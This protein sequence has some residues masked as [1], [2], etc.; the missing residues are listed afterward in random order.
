MARTSGFGFFPNQFC[1][2]GLQE[3]QVVLD[4]VPDNSVIHCVAPMDKPVSQANDLPQLWNTIL[5]FRVKVDCA[6]EGFPND[7]EPALD[8]I[9]HHG[10]AA[11][12]GEVEP[13][14]V[15]ADRLA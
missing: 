7:I 1:D 12:I 13:C 15:L 10:I 11:I 5:E 6:I 9:P 8:R 4:N 14:R 3:R 2:A